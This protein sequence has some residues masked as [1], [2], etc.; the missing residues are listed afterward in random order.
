MH[1]VECVL[2]LSPAA[3]NV[4]T[5]MMIKSVRHHTTARNDARNDA[6]SVL[7]PEIVIPSAD[8]RSTSLQMFIVKQRSLLPESFRGGCS[9]GTGALPVLPM[10]HRQATA[11]RATHQPA[12]L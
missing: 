5:A 3:P 8:A 10:F 9:F 6:P 2:V 12:F 11:G 4:R 7:L 1:E